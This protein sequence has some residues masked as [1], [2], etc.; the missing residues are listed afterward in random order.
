MPV[1]AYCLIMRA[2]EEV[3][4]CYSQNYARN[5]KHSFGIENC[6]HMGN[7][8]ALRDW[9][10]AKDYVKMQWLMLQQAN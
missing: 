7:I 4:F 6:L 8:D 10:H 5:G 9:G 2:Q 1:M 3:N